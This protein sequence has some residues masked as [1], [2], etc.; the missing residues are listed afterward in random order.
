V[1]WECLYWYDLGSGCDRAGVGNGDWLETRPPN[2]V[3]RIG[4]VWEKGIGLLPGLM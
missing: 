3:F 2:A 1:V 4:R